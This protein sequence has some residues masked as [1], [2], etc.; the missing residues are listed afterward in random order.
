MTQD[1]DTIHKAITERA[2]R[3]A[4][5]SDAF[6]QRAV[7]YR[8]LYR[9]SGGNHV[10]ALIAAH[11]S[12][13]TRQAFGGGAVIGWILSLP[14]LLTPRLRARRLAA[15]A[16]FEAAFREINR[17]VCVETLVLYHMTLQCPGH[18]RLRELA[19]PQYLDMLA[20][21]HEA[22]RRG[23]RFTEQEKHDLFDAVFRWEQDR[24]VGPGVTAAFEAFDWPLVRRASRHPLITFAYFGLRDVM[25]FRDFTD[26]VERMEKGYRA[27]GAA[28]KLG[29][30]RVERRLVWYAGI[31]GALRRL[32]RREA[33]RRPRL[34]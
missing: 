9:Q 24:I 14:Y 8:E 6:E 2:T 28:A 15:L 29:W 30:D 10:F 34:A 5:D 27:Y 19:T 22:G 11:I 33:P 12:L 32:V 17:K 31:T 25:W 4:G 16:G 20:R 23:V 26:P 13:W 18:R 7:V 1:F 3:L 21:C